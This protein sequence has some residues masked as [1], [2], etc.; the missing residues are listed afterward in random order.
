MMSG[1]E[2][3]TAVQHG[4]RPIV[5]LFNNGTYGTIRMHQER[6]HPNRVSGTDLMNPD[7]GQLAA[8][9]GAHFERVSDT[10]SFKPALERAMA[11]GRPAV[12]ELVT[13]PERISTRTTVAALRSVKANS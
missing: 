2:I 10:V 1:I 9:L 5:L 7:F 8:G 4:G 3:A 6:E 12:I 11:S 13:D